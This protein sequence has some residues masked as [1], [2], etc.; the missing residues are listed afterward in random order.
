MAFSYAKGA[1]LLSVHAA[2]YT[3]RQFRQWLVFLLSHIPYKNSVILMHN[4]HTQTAWIRADK[5]A[6]GLTASIR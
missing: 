1:R 6:T 3:Y 5:A 2:G 4:I